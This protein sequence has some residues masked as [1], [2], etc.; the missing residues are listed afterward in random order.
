MDTVK[1]SEHGQCRE[2]LAALDEAPFGR[3]HQLFVVALLAALAFDYQKPATLGFVIPGMREMFN[4]TQTPASYL[5]VSGL[6]GTP[7]RLDLLAAML[8]VAAVAMYLGGVETRDRTLEEITVPTLDQ[9]AG[10]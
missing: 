1:R 7:G 9:A 5:A 10:P 4:I 3:R 2:I 6:T 8:V